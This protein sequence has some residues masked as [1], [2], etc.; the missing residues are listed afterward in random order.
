MRF[1]FREREIVT[2]AVAG[3]TAFVLVKKGVGGMI[4]AIGPITPP[5]GLIILGLAVSS[6]VDG[7][8]ITG[9]VA[10]GVGFGLIAAGAVAL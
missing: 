2:G 1:A 9:D 5:I 10:S 7:S 8:G 4:P 6:F 3:A